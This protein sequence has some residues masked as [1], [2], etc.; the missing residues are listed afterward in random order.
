MFGMSLSFKGHGYIFRFNLEN[1]IHDH[2]LH[3]LLS[4]EVEID[5]SEPNSLLNL[6]IMRRQ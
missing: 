5:I 4:L 2:P 3:T 1:D 6:Y